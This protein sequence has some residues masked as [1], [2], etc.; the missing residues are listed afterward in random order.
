MDK[1]EEFNKHSRTLQRAKE[2]FP[3]Y[4][5][6]DH[7][8]KE[9]PW[10]VFNFRF[11]DPVLKREASGLSDSHLISIT[12]AI[13]DPRVTAD[14]AKELSRAITCALMKLRKEIGELAVADIKEQVKSSLEDAKKEAERVMKIEAVI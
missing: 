1:I 13:D 12:L 9:H 4:K 14:E 8:G 11:T 10:D 6:L 7:D 5:S 3:A 2:F